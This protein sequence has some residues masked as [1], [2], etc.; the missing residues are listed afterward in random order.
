MHMHAHVYVF[1]YVYVCICNNKCLY[2]YTC[3]FQTKNRTTKT[4]IHVYMYLNTYVY[5]HTY[6]QIYTCMHEI[7][8]VEANGTKAQEG[9]YIWR[10]LDRHWRRGRH[11][12][13]TPAAKIWPPAAA[14]PGGLPASR[15]PA[16]RPRGQPAILSVYSHYFQI[17]TAKLKPP[18]M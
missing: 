11:G 8:Y 9:L 10:T 5:L 13:R 15:P 4:N 16:R 14:R 18:E 7:S 6:T 1:M 17:R 12:P 3:V 2:T